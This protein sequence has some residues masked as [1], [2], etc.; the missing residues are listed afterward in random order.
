MPM[1]LFNMYFQQRC[2]PVALWLTQYTLFVVHSKLLSLH[3]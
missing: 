2:S 1:L 3:T